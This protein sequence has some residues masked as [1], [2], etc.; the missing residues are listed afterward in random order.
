[1]W[2]ELP[3]SVDPS[4]S[5]SASLEHLY[6]QVVLSLFSLLTRCVDSGADKGGRERVNADIIGGERVNNDK[7]L[8]R[9]AKHLLQL[10]L[11]VRCCT[12]CCENYIINFSQLSQNYP[13][14]DDWC[15]CIL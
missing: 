1:M 6:Y 8:T 5:E 15:T 13:F 14:V 12:L 11:T 4:V 2:L 10:I 7:G 9:A 3:V